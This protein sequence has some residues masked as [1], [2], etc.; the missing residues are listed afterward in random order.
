MS[1]FYLVLRRVNNE[2]M[3]GFDT[4]KKRIL[5]IKTSIGM[6]LKNGDAFLLIH[7]YFSAEMVPLMCFQ[8]A[9]SNV[10]DILL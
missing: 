5:I 8:L 7:V 6:N 10:K 2:Y 1:V 3:Q 4:L 9:N